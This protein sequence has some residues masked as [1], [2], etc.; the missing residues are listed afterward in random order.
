[1]S[2]SSVLLPMNGAALPDGTSGNAAPQVE[3]VQGTAANPKF[4]AVVLRFDPA[5]EEMAY[6]T[7]QLPHEAAAS[8]TFTLRLLWASIAAITTTN[9]VWGARISAVTAADAD[10]PIEHAQA[11]QQTATSANNTTEAGRAIAASI[12]FTNAQADG[13][14]A[15]D[16]LVVQIS[17]VAANASDTLAEDARL[18]SAALTFDLA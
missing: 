4:H 15:D 7:G 3:R 16:W 13:I 8:P 12:T 10:T 18:L 14:T 2:T 11:A 1:M 5:T 9:V 6:W 17:R